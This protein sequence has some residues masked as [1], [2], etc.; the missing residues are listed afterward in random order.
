VV[1]AILPRAAVN[2]PQ[3]VVT[4]SKAHFSRWSS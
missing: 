3:V 1:A 4:V 2:V